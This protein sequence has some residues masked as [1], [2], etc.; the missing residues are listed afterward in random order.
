MKK[1]G[2]I[3]LFFAMF[4]WAVSGYAEAGNLDFAVIQPG[5]PGTEAEA[6]PVMDAFAH[7]IQQ[8]MGSD[9]TIK[10]HYFNRLAPALA[11]LESSPPAWGIVQLG[12]YA[13]HA[14]DF[15]MTPVAA[16]RPGG[17]TKDIWRLMAQKGVVSKWQSLNGKIRG[18]ML[19]EK[20]AAAC[21]LFGLLPDRL[22]FTLEGTFRPLRSLRSL[23]KGK[24]TGVVLDRVQYETVKTM[25]MGKKDQGHAYFPG[26]AHQPG[27][28]VWGR[29][30]FNEKTGRCASGHE[31]GCKCRKTPDPSADRRLWT[32]R[33]GSAAIPAG[34]K[35]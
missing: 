8:K 12:L 1:N 32:G 35:K 2:V 14:T 21:L 16:T 17:F 7:Y 20:K 15:Q 10:G 34:R 9:E 31:G 5:Q 23:V 26:T 24:I 22:P 4:L 30:R 27:G 18:N 3:I 25:P 28:L 29:E 19:F 6:R 13:Q 33:S 11:F